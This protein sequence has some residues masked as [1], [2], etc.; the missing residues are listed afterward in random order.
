MKLEIEKHDP[1]VKILIV[2]G[3]KELV[4]YKTSYRY[5]DVFY[6]LFSKNFDYDKFYQNNFNTLYEDVDSKVYIFNFNHLESFSKQLFYRK[7]TKVLKKELLHFI[8]LKIAAYK[9]FHTFL[10]KPLEAKRRC[11]VF[12]LDESNLYF[13]YW[14]YEEDLKTFII[15]LKKNLHLSIDVTYKI[16]KQALKLHEIQITKNMLF[17]NNIL[18]RIIKTSYKNEEFQC[19]NDALTLC[20]RDVQAKRKNI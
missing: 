11:T 12:Y 6:S 16:Y 18:E 10:R 9:N 3:N 20:L 1:L 8:K 2:K 14:I 4:S 5:L 7:S 13:K 15:S 17:G 19:I